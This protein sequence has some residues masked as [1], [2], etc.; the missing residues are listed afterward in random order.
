MSFWRYGNSLY[1]FFTA[2]ISIAFI[3]IY[4]LF[5]NRLNES[6]QQDEIAPLL[7]IFDFTY[8][9]FN[10]DNGN[11]QMEAFAEYAFRAMHYNQPQDYAFNISIVQQNPSHTQS[12][13][14]TEIH[15]K[16][17]T[18]LF[19]HGVYLLQ[20]NDFIWSSKGSYNIERSFFVGE[21]DFL[22]VQGAENILNGKDIFYDYMSNFLYATHINGFFAE[23]KK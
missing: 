8:Y 16:D 17:N 18:M 22:I 12:I 13:T 3:L 23:Q 15:Y 14:S 21:G 4:L 5:H 20:N 1:I 11:V 6:I 2:L 7:E 19:P 9:T 10:T